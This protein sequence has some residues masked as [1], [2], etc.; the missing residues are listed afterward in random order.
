MKKILF[1]L[2]AASLFFAGCSQNTANEPQEDIAIFPYA[3]TW[4]LP[5]QMSWLVINMDSSVTQCIKGA[6]VPFVAH[7]TITGNRI[8]WKDKIAMPSTV[9]RQKDQLTVIWGN[10][11]STTYDLSGEARP[12]PGC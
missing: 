1:T 11:P 12:I 10:T 7:G 5:G 2:L 6:E 9:E 3:G 8:T 4:M